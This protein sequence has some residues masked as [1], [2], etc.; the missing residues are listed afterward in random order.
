MA[1]LKFV[2]FSTVPPGE[3]P[4]AYV[5]RESDGYVHPPNYKLEVVDVPITDLR[6]V[7][8]SKFTLDDN[9]FRV[10]LG[11]SALSGDDFFDEDKVA[12]IYLPE[13]Q[14]IVQ[15]ATE[16]VHTKVFDVI[17]RSER[18]INKPIDTVHG[19]YT[20]PSGPGRVRQHFSPEEA[21]RLLQSRYAIVNL[22]RPIRTAYDIPLAVA[23]A[24][25]S[26]RSEIVQQN[27]V[28]PNRVGV[29]AAF[30]HNPK[31][32]FYY[33][34]QQTPE[35]AFLF[36][37]FEK[38]DDKAGFVP[39]GAFTDPTAPPNAPKRESIEVRLLVFWGAEAGEA[40]K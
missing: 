21:D 6:S 1:P 22:W 13:V 5:P 27:L 36:K 17:V 23:D 3:N 2:D 29:I 19:D 38:A 12:N 33:F 26:P 31:T 37:T 9:G 10:V 8:A 20:I 25:T 28:Y 16:A 34:S 30:R 18:S 35:E 40:S 32:Q 11:P 24:S 15:K 7:D 39:H 4:T 14:G